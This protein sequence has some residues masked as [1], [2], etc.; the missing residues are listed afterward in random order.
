MT[1]LALRA[2]KYLSKQSQWKYSNLELQ[3]ILYIA[4][5]F[6]FGADD[7]PLVHG[8]FEAWEFGPVHPDL[9]HTLKVF[10]A[11]SV[12]RSFGIF[13]FTADLEEGSESRWLSD[14]AVAFPPGS[15]PGLV[16]FTRQ[17]HTAWSKHYKHGE[18]FNVIPWES[19]VDEYRLL[20]RAC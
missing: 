9:Y 20:T 10:G 12:P 17:E 3:K 7:S 16:A 15:G 4:H 19:I 6:H 11:R 13:D 2:A 1:I 8:N 14:A 5:V 18:C